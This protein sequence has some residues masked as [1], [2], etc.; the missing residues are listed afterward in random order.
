[1]G[2]YVAPADWNAV[3]DDPDTVVIDYSSP[4]VA[5][6][7]HVGHIRS[8][9]IG[10][11]LARI[12]RF[13]GHQVIADNHLGDWGLPIAMVLHELRA[14]GTDLDTL[15]LSMLDEAYRGLMG[16]LMLTPAS[17]PLPFE[18]HR[19]LTSFALSAQ[20]QAAQETDTPPSSD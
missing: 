7:M 13:L 6:P 19:F 8:T 4:N 10:D 12:L 11:A 18:A 3:I 2:A 1:M 15:D 14:A 20:Q 17:V 5:K 16:R 9:V